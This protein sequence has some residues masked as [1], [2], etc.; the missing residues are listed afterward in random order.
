MRISVIIPAYNAADCIERAVRS[1]LDQTLPPYEIIVVDDAST[2]RTRLIVEEIAARE[3]RV[4]LLALAANGGPSAARN[5]GLDHVTG[6][7]VAILDADD[8]M[9]PRRFEAMLAVAQKDGLDMVADN[10]DLLDYHAGRTLE[11]AFGWLESEQAALTT[12]LYLERDVTGQDYG[13]GLIKPVFRKAFLDGHGLR[14]PVKYRHGEDSYF[15]TVAL[16]LGAKAVLLREAYYIYIPAIGP[17]SGKRSSYSRTRLDYLKKAESCLDI[18][19]LYKE[20]MSEKSL[21]LMRYR[22]D[23]I[24]DFHENHMARA[25]IREKKFISAFGRIVRRPAI[26]LPL[27]R[28]LLDKV[29]Q[30]GAAK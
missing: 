26:A 30:R 27:G 10:I 2:D 25:D 16:I 5:A 29:L 22:H 19:G 23:R 3:P 20:R 13:L 7:W 24:L 14:Y 9:K 6:E 11:R 8:T 21:A 17:F 4:R 15:Y 1:A 12:E 18:I 28:A